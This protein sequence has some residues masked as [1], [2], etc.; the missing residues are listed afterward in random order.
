MERR[1]TVQDKYRREIFRVCGDLWA[2]SATT[3]VR[4]VAEEGWPL[5]RPDLLV[6]LP[7]RDDLYAGALLADVACREWHVYLRDV[8]VQV[9][10]PLLQH[11]PPA[12]LEGNPDDQCLLM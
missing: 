5:H 10:L 2:M 7:D 8:Y 9:L 11:R 3:A 12:V 6:L 4:H 1:G